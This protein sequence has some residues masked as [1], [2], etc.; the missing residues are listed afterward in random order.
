MTAFIIG[1]KNV[2]VFADG[3]EAPVGPRDAEDQILR[4]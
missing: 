3:H 2:S 4:G 1:E